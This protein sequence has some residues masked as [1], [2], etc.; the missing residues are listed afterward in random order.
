MQCQLDGRAAT[1]GDL[2]GRR[3]AVVLGWVERFEGE[4]RRSPSQQF[5]N[6]V[7]PQVR[8]REQ[9]SDRGADGDGCFGTVFSISM[10]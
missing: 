10:R 8:P 3:A 1:A 6:N 7:E 5:R 9:A 4:G 2:R